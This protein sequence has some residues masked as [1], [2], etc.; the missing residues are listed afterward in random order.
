VE[1]L[2]L[3]PGMTPALAAAMRPHV[4]VA[5]LGTVN[6]NTADELV[7]QAAGLNASHVAALLAQR[8]AAPLT[9]VPSDFP[10][11]LGVQS[12]HFE[13][14]V[15]AAVSGSAARVRRAAILDRSGVIRSWSYR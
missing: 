8:Q 14:P 4:T 2:L 11:G 3:V 1:E 9:S 6:V 12:S 15:V 5:G 13:A 10:A 7:L